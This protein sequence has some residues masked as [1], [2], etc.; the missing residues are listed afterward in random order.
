MT[1]RIVITGSVARDVLM[2]YPGL[3]SEQFVGDA[4][5]ISLSF[6]VA[7][8]VVRAGGTAANIA[9][10]CA[11][12]GDRPE[13]AVAIGEDFREEG[14]VLVRR[15]VDLSRSHW[16]RLATATC[17]ITTDRAGAQIAS[18][19]PGA[20]A[21]SREVHLQSLSPADWLLVTPG[22]PAAMEQHLREAFLQGA[23]ILFAPGQQLTTLAGDLVARSIGQSRVVV[24]NEYEEELVVAH[25]GA[26]V[27]ELAPAGSSVVITL[28]RDGSKVYEGGE[29]THVAA[30]AVAGLVDPTGAG[31]AFLAGMSHVLA[32]GGSAVEGARWGTALASFAL[33]GQ[34]AQGYQPAFD[35]IFARYQQ[36]RG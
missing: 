16:S 20:M 1:A 3:F 30:L 32:A 10:G 29:T 17:Y 21:D 33:E 31:D 13:L 7:D 19:Y 9:H 15:G 28:G 8:Q 27:V 22:D 24:L 34:G 2:S 5:K 6:L 35:E 18:F 11:L 25:C 26:S 23:Q 14:E 12:L 4:G 36:V